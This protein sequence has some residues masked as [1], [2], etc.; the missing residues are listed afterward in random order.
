MDGANGGWAVLYGPLDPSGQTLDLVVDE[1]MLT[2]AE[3]AHITERAAYVVV[4]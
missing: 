3:R 2:D 1:D 4:E